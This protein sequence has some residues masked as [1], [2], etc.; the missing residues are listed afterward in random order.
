MSVQVV[1]QRQRGEDTSG[2]HY[3]IYTS[4]KWC[5][6]DLPWQVLPGVKLN[7]VEPAS[8]VPGIRLQL[9]KIN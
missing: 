9:T 3:G 5:I 4:M 2:H 7:P 1:R 6:V 8:E